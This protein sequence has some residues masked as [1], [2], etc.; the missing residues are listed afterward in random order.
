MV[1][2]DFEDEDVSDVK[3]RKS[4]KVISTGNQEIDKKLGGGIPVGSMVLVEGESD[5]GK[6]VLT[7]QLL[8]PGG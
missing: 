1:E 3:P 7:Q 6:S 4:G 8:L 5:S 2:K